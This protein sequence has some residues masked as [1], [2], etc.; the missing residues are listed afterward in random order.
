MTD[1]DAKLAEYVQVLG[2]FR[3]ANSL[4]DDW[5]AVPDH[6]AIKCADGAEY[7]AEMQAWL[8][9]AAQAQSVPLNGRLLGSLR[10][11][12]PLKT[13]GLGQVEWLEVMEPRPEKVGV[14]PVGI[15]HMEFCFGDFDAAAKAL[16]EKGIAYDSQENPGHK[17]LSIM[18]DGHE[19]KLTD[20]SLADVVASELASG[21]A[22]ALKG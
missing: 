13:S 15:D 8:P 12:Q 1:F 20:K 6:V 2:A 11:L 21:T 7:E 3:T 19:F 5:F 18:A 17:W 14:D 16:G 10:L 22:T 4:P 9:E